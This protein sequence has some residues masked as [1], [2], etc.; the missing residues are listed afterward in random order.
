[1][2]P[3]DALLEAN[4]ASAGARCQI[5]NLAAQSATRIL[6]PFSGRTAPTLVDSERVITCLE[7]IPTIDADQTMNTLLQSECVSGAPA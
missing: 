1:M 5:H 2:L 7:T 4:P 3:T 6:G